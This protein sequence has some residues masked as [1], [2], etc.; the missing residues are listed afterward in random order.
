[1]SW[2]LSPTRARSL[3]RSIGVAV[4]STAFVAFVDAA[5]I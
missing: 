1:M 2:I 5:S 3:A 4:A